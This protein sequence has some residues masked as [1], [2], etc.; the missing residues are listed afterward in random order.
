MP[1]DGIFIRKVF[2]RAGLYL[3]STV[4]FCIKVPWTLASP[5]PLL[6]TH[7][8]VI[9]RWDL[10]VDAGVTIAVLRREHSRVVKIF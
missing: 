8:E 1:W 9:G 4:P 7:I 5:G 2:W 3:L 10:V 6:W